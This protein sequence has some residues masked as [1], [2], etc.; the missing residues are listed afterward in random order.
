M[1]VPVVNILNHP[2]MIDGPLGRPGSGHVNFIASTAV[3]WR[4]FH[5]TPFCAKDVQSIENDGGQ[6]QATPPS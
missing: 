6:N 3:L 4:E 5:H 1:N 2:L